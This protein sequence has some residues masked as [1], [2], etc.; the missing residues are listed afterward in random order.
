MSMDEIEDPLPI[1]LFAESLALIAVPS[2]AII[3]FV[4]LIGSGGVGEG[5]RHDAQLL[6]RAEFMAGLVVAALLAGVPLALLLLR[7]A[8]ATL[9]RWIVTGALCGAAVGVAATVFLVWDLV[10]QAGVP[11]ELIGRWIAIV[12]AFGAMGAVAAL[13]IRALTLYR[14]R[15][16]G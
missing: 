11:N 9:Q 10:M 8:H 2:A 1:R 5:P 7:D 4:S 15:R 12:L 6:F 3:F 16:R 13:P 14:F